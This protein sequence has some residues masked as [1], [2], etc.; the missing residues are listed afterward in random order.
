MAFGV[1][2]LLAQG[3]V[4]RVMSNCEGESETLAI[5]SRIRYRCACAAPDFMPLGWN[6]VLQEGRWNVVVNLRL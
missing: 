1:R 3:G 6:L 2:L 5:A 4:V